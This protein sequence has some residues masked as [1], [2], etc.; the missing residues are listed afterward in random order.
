MLCSNRNLTCARKGG[1][2]S[3]ATSETSE[4][5]PASNQS[6]ARTREH[7]G[8]YSQR[9]M[10]E[11]PYITCRQLIDFI[12]DYVEGGLDATPRMDFERHLAVC[13]SCRVYLQTY[14]QTQSMARSLLDSDDV[15]EDVPE[16]LV[17]TILAAGRS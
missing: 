2:P 11:R 10:D 1:S 9:E 5:G 16:G 3:R 7:G 8:L 15:V 6:I 12:A 4:K 17:E 13:P 14:R